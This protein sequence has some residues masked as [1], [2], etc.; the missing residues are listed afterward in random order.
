MGYS[1]K[2]L[3]KYKFLLNIFL[4]RDMH[5]SKLIQ[6]HGKRYCSL[7]KVHGENSLYKGHKN[8]CG[9][10]DCQCKLCQ[11]VRKRQSS[12][13]TSIKVEREKIKQEQ[14]N[15]NKAEAKK[16]KIILK[17]LNECKPTIIKT[18]ASYLELYDFNKKVQSNK[19]IE[20]IAINLP[21]IINNYFFIC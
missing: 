6:K 14:R 17:M 21:I 2:Q 4:D 12:C 10:V 18:I 1:V 3:L 16:F 7:C 8:Q 9:Y 5:L 13:K 20:G 11:P 19:L 15:E